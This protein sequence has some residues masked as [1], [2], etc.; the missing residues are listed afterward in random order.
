MQ[1]LWRLVKQELSN[2]RDQTLIIAAIARFL[3]WI[4][5]QLLRSA[6]G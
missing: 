1:S 6:F 5:T 2:A 3:A 4:I